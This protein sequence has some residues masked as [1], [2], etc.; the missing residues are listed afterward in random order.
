MNSA[1]HKIRKFVRIYIIGGQYR[2]NTGINR[3][4]ADQIT[5]GHFPFIIVFGCQQINYPETC[6]HPPGNFRVYLQRNINCLHHFL[7]YEAE[8]LNQID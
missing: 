2:E 8:A 6:D 5:A 3:C 1:E 7:D 4:Q